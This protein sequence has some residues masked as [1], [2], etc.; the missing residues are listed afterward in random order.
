M[1]SGG[2]DPAPNSDEVEDDEGDTMSVHAPPESVS[3]SMSRK[4]SSCSS[5]SSSMSVVSNG[6]SDAAEEETCSTSMSACC[7]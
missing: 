4:D 3:M 7:D 5:M 2:T 1:S 6:S